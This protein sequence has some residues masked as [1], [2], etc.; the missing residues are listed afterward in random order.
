M[1]Q[2]ARNGTQGSFLE[3]RV[4][5]TIWYVRLMVTFRSIIHYAE[6]QSSKVMMYQLAIL[7]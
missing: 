5:I 3:Y 2:L 4:L 1:E 6:I 7:Q